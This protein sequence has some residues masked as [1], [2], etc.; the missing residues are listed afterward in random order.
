[1]P[2]N[3]LWPRCRAKI[4][5]VQSSIQR[6][7]QQ[8]KVSNQVPKHVK[9]FYILTMSLLSLVCTLSFNSINRNT[10]LAFDLHWRIK[11]KWKKIF[12][13]LKCKTMVKPCYLKATTLHGKSKQCDQ[14][15]LFFK[16]HKNSPNIRRLLGNF[17][18]RHFLVA[19]TC[20]HLLGKWATFIP[21][22]GHTEC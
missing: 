7:Q 19:A 12:V 21:T 17:E 11:Q 15:G 2:D 10:L 3:I 22:S 6:F 8:L 18:K 9:Q 1:M 13:V 16:S 4:S 20:G 14:I 5:K